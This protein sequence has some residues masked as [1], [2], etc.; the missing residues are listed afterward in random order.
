MEPVRATSSAECWPI[1]GPKLTVQMS[2]RRSSDG[3]ATGL[4]VSARA[5]DGGPSDSVCSIQVLLTHRVLAESAV[6]LGV[7]RR[8]LGRAD[9]C[10]EHA[11]E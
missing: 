4:P 8:F 6:I 2:P 11:R 10:I 5:A 3:R 1:A 7:D 9:S